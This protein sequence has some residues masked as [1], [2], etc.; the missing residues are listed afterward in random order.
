MRARGRP[1]A[2]RWPAFPRRSSPCW[3]RSRPQ[4]PCHGLLQAPPDRR[5]FIGARRQQR[6]L[7]QKIGGFRA[8]INPRCRARYGQ[9]PVWREL[10]VFGV[11]PSKSP[12]SAHRSGK[13]TTTCRS[14]RP[15]RINAEIEH[16]VRL[17]AAMMMIPSCVSKPSIS[18]SSGVEASARARRC[19]SRRGR[20]RASVRPRQFHQ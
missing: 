9:I 20:G 10:H 16:V 5:P 8:R 3:R 19:P 7:V 11:G 14:K 4:R 1:R 13:L 2:R 12:R 15:G 6:R 17:V 18:T